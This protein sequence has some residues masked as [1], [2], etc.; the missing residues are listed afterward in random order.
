MADTTTQGYQELEE[1][2]KLMEKLNDVVK[3]AYELFNLYDPA[4][5]TTHNNSSTAHPD[6]RDSISK[7]QVSVTN[8]KKAHDTSIE[9]VKSDYTDKISKVENTIN[10][11]INEDGGVAFAKKAQYNNNGYEL[12]DTIV[13][14]IAYNSS[15]NTVSYTRINNKKGSFAIN[16]VS[17]TVPG[18][19]TP[20]D[21]TKLDSAAS[22]ISALQVNITKI[23]S[24]QEAVTDTEVE[25]MAQDAWSPDT[26]VNN[27]ITWVDKGYV[28]FRNHF[29]LD[30]LQDTS[31]Q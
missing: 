6:I 26:T 27:N 30:S 11:L 31:W 7:V 1:H 5:V 18:L 8:L 3:A 15:T 14:D 20:D 29:N 21:K 28:A 25:K 2:N 24:N 22:D 13:K 12:V 16:K 4:V 19:M 10:S 23:E 17:S 9:E